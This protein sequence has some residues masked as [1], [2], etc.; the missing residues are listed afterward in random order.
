MAIKSGKEAVYA[1]WVEEH[2]SELYRY[3]Y[4]LGGRRELAED[5][6]QETFYHAWRSFSSLH[7]LDKARP[8]LYRILRNRYS[9]YVRA[10]VRRPQ[11]VALDSVADRRDPSAPNPVADLGQSDELTAALAGLEDRFREPMLM[12]FLEGKTCRE[13]ADELG[14]P[15]GT[16]LSRIHRARKTLRE[17]LNGKTQPKPDREKAGYKALPNLGML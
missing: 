9:H 3:A 10:Q 6:V 13:A 8:W 17:Q 7:E 4:R 5:L 16:V 11:G 2:S 12:V 14:V 1:G 15:L